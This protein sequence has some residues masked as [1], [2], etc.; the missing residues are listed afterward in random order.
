MFIDD[1]IA[2]IPKV[3]A[4]ENS[5]LNFKHVNFNTEPRQM[6]Y[7]LKKKKKE[8]NFR[9]LI[10]LIVHSIFLTYNF[11]SQTPHIAT[12]IINK[13]EKPERCV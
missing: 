6:V 9:Y 11:L 10:A 13:N 8:I 12:M 2:C 3:L 5:F 1:D 4:L 7:Q